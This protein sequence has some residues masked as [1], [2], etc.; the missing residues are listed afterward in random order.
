[1]TDLQIKEGASFPIVM[2]V[3]SQGLRFTSHAQLD[4]PQLPDDITELDDTSLMELFS[5]LTAYGNF[6]S[7]QLACAFIDERQADSALEF[8]ESVS[9]IEAAT[10]NKKE[11]VALLKARMNTNPE[12]MKLKTTQQEA[13]AY[14]KI[15]E[16]MS[17]NVEKDTSLVSRELSRRIG[18]QAPSMRSQRF[19]A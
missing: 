11:T 9:Y 13:Y 18:G 5:K 12:V 8:A 6:L 16:V 19:N 7:T 2:Q 17:N 1:V 10:S 3:K 15:V 14:R 4:V